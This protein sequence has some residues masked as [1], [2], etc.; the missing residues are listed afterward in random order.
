MERDIP[1]DLLS[2]YAV[3][4]MPIQRLRVTSLQSHFTNS[5]IR[6]SKKNDVLIDYRQK[7]RNERKI[8][9]KESDF[10]EKIEGFNAFRRLTQSGEFNQLQEDKKKIEMEEKLPY[11]EKK[12]NELA[13][14]KEELEK[15]CIVNSQ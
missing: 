3:I 12:S 2:A 9:S 13:F 8:I 15:N 6:K 4:N 1:E 7:Y 11:L 14:G 5:F 10:D